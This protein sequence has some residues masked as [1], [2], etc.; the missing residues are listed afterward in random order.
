M[1]PRLIKTEGIHNGCTTPVVN[2]PTKQG[3]PAPAH[4]RQSDRDLS[5]RRPP[6]VG[7]SAMRAAAVSWAIRAR[8]QPTGTFACVLGAPN[9]T[10]ARTVHTA[11]ISQAA[12]AGNIVVRWTEVSSQKAVLPGPLTYAHATT[13]IPP[14]RPSQA[15]RSFP[16][17]NVARSLDRTIP[18]TT[19]TG[20]ARRRRCKWGA[21]AVNVSC[22]RELQEP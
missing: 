12:V 20:T 13:N 10:R 11:R 9:E 6:P 3:G 7:W 21:M 14:R 4:L 2:N 22:H 17:C 15:Q 18:A 16:R 5:I 8:T 19:A 1:P